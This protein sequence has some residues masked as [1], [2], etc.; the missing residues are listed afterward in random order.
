MTGLL[1]GPSATQPPGRVNTATATKLT[2]AGAH[3]LAAAIIVPVITRR[4][5]RRL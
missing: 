3:L 4:L 1:A 2:L 5:A